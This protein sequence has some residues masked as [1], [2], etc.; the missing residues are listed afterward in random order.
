MPRAL[1][2]PRAAQAAKRS[3]HPQGN[4]RWYRVALAGALVTLAALGGF[5]IASANSNRDARV[6]HEVRALLTGIPQDGQTLGTPTAPVTMQLFADL[7]DNDSQLW[8]L[9]LLPTII[10]K[11]VRTSVLKIEYR[12]FKT[13]T[14]DSETFLK[15]QAAA[16]AAGTQD[17][18]WN[19]AYTFYFD[20]GQEY[21]PY[22]TET[23]LEN[24]AHQV[25]TL[26]IQQWDTD[27]NA[28]PQI[29]QVVEQDQQ[30]RAAGIHV[31]PAYRIGRTGGTLKNFAGSKSIT[32]A[33]QEHPTTYASAEDLAKAINE[34]H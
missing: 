34:I 29:E 4:A 15:Q 16:L 14:I 28:D 18:L 23:Y 32:F 5:M 13:N 21:T 24:I 25:P 30:G 20:Q 11:F 2:A 33:H 6:D 1:A 7:E 26:N 27:R 3:W 19:Y 17:K 10:R 22:V 12:A 9:K 8:F 31:T